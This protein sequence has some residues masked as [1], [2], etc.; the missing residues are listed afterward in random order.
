MC[1]GNRLNDIFYAVVV[2]GAKNFMIILPQGQP[3]G[4]FILVLW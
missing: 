4:K 3:E 1:K 2:Q